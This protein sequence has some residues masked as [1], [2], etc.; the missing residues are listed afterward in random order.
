GDGWDDILTWDY[1]KHVLVHEND[2][3]GGFKTV[4]NVN[5]DN[6]PRY[7]VA[8]DFDHDQDL[9][10]VVSDYNTGVSA[11][12]HNTTFYSKVFNEAT[13]NDYTSLATV[14]QVL[15][16]KTGILM[17]QNCSYYRDWGNFNFL[18]WQRYLL[19]A[20]YR[21]MWFNDFDQSGSA[22]LVGYG[23][24]GL[25]I[26]RE[27]QQPVDYDM[28][29]YFTGVDCNDFDTLINPGVLEIP[30]NLVD[31]NCDGIV[32]TVD[33][34]GDGFN[35]DID[36]NDQDSTINP[37]AIEIPGNSIDE[38]CD[39]LDVFGD[40]DMDGYASDVDCNDQNP[41]I[42]PGA[43]DIP[44]NNI[45]EDCDGADAPSYFINRKKLIF[46]FPVVDVDA[47]DF[48]KDGMRDVLYTSHQ[49]IGWTG[50][51]SSG[52]S[53]SGYVVFDNDAI[54]TLA[55]A[56]DFDNDGDIDVV[57]ASDN[58]NTIALYKNDGLGHFAPG[59]KVDSSASVIAMNI[60]DVDNDGFLD[61]AA[62]FSNGA[63]NH[64]SIYFGNGT[65][66]FIEKKVVTDLV[67]YNSEFFVYDID[68][69]HDLDLFISTYALGMGWY[70]NTGNRIFSTRKI[71]CSE[72]PYPRDLFYVDYDKDDVKE[73]VYYVGGDHDKQPGIQVYDWVAGNIVYR[74]NIIQHNNLG[75]IYPQDM[76]G[77]CRVDFVWG[78]NSYLR[79]GIAYNFNKTPFP[80]QVMRDTS[81]HI[82]DIIAED[83]NGDGNP[84][85]ILGTNTPNSLVIIRNDFPSIDGDGDGA[86]QMS[87]CDYCNPAIHPGAT[88]IPNNGIDED[89]DG[90]DLVTGVENTS[91]LSFSIY[92]NPTSGKIYFQTNSTDPFTISVFNGI[93]QVVMKNIH[94]HEIDLTGKAPGIY[95][96]LVDDGKRTVVRRFVLRG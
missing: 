60:G 80:E 93:G 4:F 91:P 43:F 85:L 38:N 62:T 61:I 12:K 81:L 51:A 30:N 57:G 36:C 65:G 82:W 67:N 23:D 63:A 75:R 28:D 24:G 5:T 55:K 8:F 46:D 25:W 68:G 96:I 10:I 79:M 2:K 32:L 59:I 3:A 69:D 95:L 44:L 74:E 35:S 76:N 94:D 31:E 64:P 34:D 41:E 87:D 83:L 73:L 11:Y 71:I 50:Y 89:C 56:G 37:M 78:G 19:N 88:E 84:E 29:G 20:N 77:D 47:A 49:L 22:E 48:N 1:Y 33:L 40:G 39:G 21:Q 70:E 92:P 15:D 66:S 7:C 53:P 26:H 72:C 58:W 6:A 16:G 86:D 14:D 45:D 27:A 18:I 54:F 17:G 52:I 13:N 9:D 90:F 42:S